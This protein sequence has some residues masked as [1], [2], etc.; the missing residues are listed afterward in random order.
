[1]RKYLAVVMT[2]ILSLNM[3]VNAAEELEFV[4]TDN[5][6]SRDGTEY[7]YAL[8]GIK[9]YDTND[10][11]KY[12]FG[13]EETIE[14]DGLFYCLEGIEYS[15]VNLYEKEYADKVI[16]YSVIVEET[17]SGEEKDTFD[18]D[19][20]ITKS[21]YSYKYDGIEFE[22]VSSETIPL[23]SYLETELL[24][25]EL[26]ASDYPDTMPYEYEGVMYDLKYSDYEIISQGWHDGY[27]LYGTITNY[28][29][30]TYQVG[31]V[32]I[33]NNDEVFDLDPRNYVE[34]LEGL[35]IPTD[36]YQVVSVSY[37]GE[38]YTNSDGVVCRDYV[39][40]AQMNGTR[41]KL[42]YRYDLQKSEYTAKITYLLSDEEVEYIEE[43]KNS[44]E[45]SAVAYY[46]IQE[47]E[48]AEDDGLSVAIKIAIGTGIV[49]L[50]AIIITLIVYLI[51]GGRRR[52]ED[53]NNRELK[54]EFKHL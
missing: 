24:Q 16:D 5:T 31:N 10:E 41:Y 14:N 8:S 53:M 37:N 51:R 18:P 43:L 54:D 2:A 21:G 6:V 49:I 17:V 4:N 3:T 20:E 45:V 48:Q 46:S 30:A 7:D 25:G 40:N 26:V 35:E 42:N 33:E 19:E 23:S 34:F 50:L 47:Q 32:V 38:A 22:E 29:A 28:D 27:Y 13:F 39:I 36:K 9:V 11:T 12:D 52:T 1:M 44:Y 15:T